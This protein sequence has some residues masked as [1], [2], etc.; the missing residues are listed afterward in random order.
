MVVLHLSTQEKFWQHL[1]AAVDAPD[2]AGDPRFA[3]RDDRIENYLQLNDELAA[4]FKRR[5]REEWLERLEQHDIPSAPMNSLIEALD[6]PQVRALD[7]MYQLLDG[8][9]R[10]IVGIKPPILADGKRPGTARRP[11]LLGEHTA[12]VIAELES[13]RRS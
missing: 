10:T 3:T 11:P 6:H 12:E 13:S 9:G 4:Y 8:E 1:V 5:S 7:P 2:L